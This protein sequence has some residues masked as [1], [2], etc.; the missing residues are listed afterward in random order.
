MDSPATVQR[1][2]LRRW[3]VLLGVLTLTGVA[4]GA[5]ILPAVEKIREAS[6]RAK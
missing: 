2:T 5:V 4:V 1:E 3:A 6:D